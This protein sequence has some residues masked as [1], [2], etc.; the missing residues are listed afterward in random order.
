MHVADAIR[1]AA[2][3]SA[4]HE[5]RIYVDA[6]FDAGGIPMVYGWSLSPEYSENTRYAFAEGIPIL[7][8]D[9]SLIEKF[10]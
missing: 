2:I 8:D 5:C 6:T 9:V 4:I 7:C 10:A 1:Q 3:K